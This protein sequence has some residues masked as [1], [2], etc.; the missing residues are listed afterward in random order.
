MPDL[1]VCMIVK[2]EE[3]Y[4]RDCLKSLLPVSPEFIIVDTG[5][6]D[7]T[8]RIANEF[9]V[10]LFDMPWNNNF[11]YTRNYALSKATGKWIFYIDADERL[12]SKSIKELL[13]IVKS[14]IFAGIYCNL[15]SVDKQGGRPNVMKYIR[16]FRA[17]PDIRFKGRV[18]EQIFGSLNEQG[19]S[20]H[21]SGIKLIHLGYDVPRE[22]LEAKAE[23]NLILLLEDFNEIKD[24]YTAFQIASSY[25]VMQHNTKAA[26][27]F[28]YCLTD[29]SLASHYNAHANRFLA[30]VALE[31]NDVDSASRFILSALEA[32]PDAPLVNV[33][34]AKVC[35]RK[36]ELLP[37]FDFYL[38]G[39]KNNLALL[40]GKA[41]SPFDIMI[42]PAELAL[43]GISFSVRYQNLPALEFY[44]NELEISEGNSDDSIKKETRIL[45]KF[46]SNT[47]LSSSELDFLISLFIEGKNE[48]YCE[49]IARLPNK[50]FALDLLS[51]LYK[52]SSDS[53]IAE[54]LS[55]LYEETGNELLAM[56]FASESLTARPKNLSLLLRKISILIRENKID[57]CI[58]ILA[59]SKEI[60]KD[61]VSKIQIIDSVIK[62]INNL[63]N[64]V[65]ITK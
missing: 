3:K 55:L 34:A 12:S 26:E 9:S 56:Q 21:D 45:R 43:Q 61:D 41:V 64:A 22:Q 6:T 65:T 36:N 5:S 27:Y 42:D 20:I 17:H 49:L 40:Q 13:H 16:L 33:I 10:K 29:A 18:H 57:D 39:Y 19:Y 48:V 51:G 7:A 25:A 47:T 23:R 35:F 38:K 8:K 1:S 60:F 53:Y 15:Q 52:K 37:G 54:A 30:A 32:N 4:L 58:S 59:D 62:K 11:S 50:S 31:K 24:G 46:F 63:V 28:E 14:N 44:L 2:N